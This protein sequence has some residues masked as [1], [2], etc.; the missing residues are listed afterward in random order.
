[1]G[2]VSGIVVF[3]LI[4]W[5][6]IF[7]VL[8]LRIERQ[9]KNSNTDGFDRGAPKEAHMKFKFILTTGITLA[10]WLIYYILVET[11]V[12]THEFFI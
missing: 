2:I 9:D 1:M 10:L 5:I 8:P 3:L 12:L 7:T 11:G 4:W 6:V